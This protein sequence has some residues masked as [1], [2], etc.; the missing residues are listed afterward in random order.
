[1][2]CTDDFCSI[3]QLF[4]RSTENCNLLIVNCLKMQGCAIAQE[5]RALTE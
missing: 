1:M 3:V 2:C 5:K 4:N